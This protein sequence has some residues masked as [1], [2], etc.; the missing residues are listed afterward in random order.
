MT[1]VPDA[2]QAILD[3]FSLITARSDRQ[4]YL[5]ELAGHFEEV[6]IDPDIAQPPYDEIH[7]VP[8]CESEAYVWAFPND[9][10]TLRF[11]FD[12]RNPQGLSAMAMCVVLGRSCSHAPLDQV[13]ALDPN[14]VFTLFGRDLSMGKGLGLTGIVRMVSGLARGNLR[15]GG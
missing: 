5:I 14:L 9:D 4:E 10:H 1:G 2:L 6:R 13:A 11:A 12:V 8:G 7:R 15:A 3:D